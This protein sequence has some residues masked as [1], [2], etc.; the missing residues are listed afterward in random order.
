MPP[1][2]Y[3]ASVTLLRSAPVTL[4]CSASVRGGEVGGGHAGG[5]HAGGGDAGWGAARGAHFACSHYDGDAGVL[6]GPDCGGGGG[7]D[8]DLA[9]QQRA[10]H[11]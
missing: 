8:G 7:R 3:S 11:V 9:V 10:V 1:A 5:M 2:T 6:C 4:L